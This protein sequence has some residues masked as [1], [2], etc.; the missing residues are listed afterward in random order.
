MPRSRWYEGDPIMD[1]GPWTALVAFILILGV[2]LGS[3]WLQ[4]PWKEPLATLIF[5][6]FYIEFDACTRQVEKLMD[7]IKDL[8]GQM[9]N[10]EAQAKKL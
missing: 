4:I 8:E 10:L 3:R 2:V 7:R 1:H 5:V 6:A 9:R